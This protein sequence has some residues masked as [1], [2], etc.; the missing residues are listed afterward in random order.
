V[1]DIVVTKLMFTVSSRDE[2]LLV[3]LPESPVVSLYP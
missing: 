3:T 1:Y 2:L